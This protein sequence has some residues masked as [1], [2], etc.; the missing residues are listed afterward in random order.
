MPNPVHKPDC[1]KEDPPDYRVEVTASD[2]SRLE[3]VLACVITGSLLL[4]GT[5]P[6]RFSAAPE[7]PQGTAGVVSSGELRLARLGQ[8]PER[9]TEYRS[10]LESLPADHVPLE[11]FWTDDDGI[12]VL[13]ILVLAVAAQPPAVSKFLVDELFEE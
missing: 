8:L 1:G 3:Q 13:G 6:V 12:S 10:T 2:P 9:L 11:F 4:A 7:P 5:S